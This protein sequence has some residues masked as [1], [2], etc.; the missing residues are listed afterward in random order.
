MPIDLSPFT[1]V[2]LDLDGT[3]YH[4]ERPLPGA[5]ALI[6]RLQAENRKFACLSNSTTSPLRI[7]DRLRRM[8]V[9]IDPSHVY[10]A[11]A[12]TADYVLQ[13]FG[14][15][16]RP[17]VFNL[18]T[19]GIHDM[20]DGSV[21]WV[22]TAGEPCDAVIAGA[23]VNV[24]ATEERNRVALQLLRKNAALVGICAD[25]VYPSARG[26]EFGSGAFCA[27]LGFAA[28]VTPTFCGKPNAI[29]FHELC[30]RLGVT[31]ESCLLIGDNIEA[32]V[33]GGQAVGMKTA[34]VLTGV[35]RRRDLLAVPK[36]YHPAFVI[37]E[38]TDV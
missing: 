8:G 36:E 3:V 6:Q 37:E 35:T 10:S 28:R 5:I 23:P 11:A 29:F 33:M 25:R 9:E 26:I 1:A 13:T 16:R 4:D 12:A 38:L 21:D 20:L 30:R 22:S 14:S 32:D 34:L 7:T 2:L 24:Y 19:R 31:P 27:M 18:A 17:R 15:A